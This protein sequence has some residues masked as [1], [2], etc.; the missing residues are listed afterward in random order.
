MPGVM[1]TWADW[2]AALLLVLGPAMQADEE[3]EPEPVMD[4]EFLEYLGS[5][6]ASDDEW[7]LFDR[8]EDEPD[9][10]ADE[11]AENGDEND[12]ES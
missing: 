1:K 10:G 4:M 5:W 3:A 12:D 11:D 8:A 9:V 6:D 7:L 2:P